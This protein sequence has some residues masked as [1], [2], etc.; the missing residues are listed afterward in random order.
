MDT[1]EVAKLPVLDE[2]LLWQLEKT[3]SFTNKAFGYSNCC[4]VEIFLTHS[5]VIQIM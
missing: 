3:K 4:H 1:A 5:P 2:H